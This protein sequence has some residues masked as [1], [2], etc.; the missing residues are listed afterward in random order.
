MFLLMFFLRQTQAE[1]GRGI[2]SFVDRQAELRA[3]KHVTVF[4]Y[5]SYDNFFIK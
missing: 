5:V 2:G 1:A 4:L 3:G